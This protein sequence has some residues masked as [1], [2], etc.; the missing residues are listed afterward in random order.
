MATGVVTGIEELNA[1]LRQLRGPLA[2]KA[3]RKSSREALKPLAPK[4][5]RA[6]PQRTGRLS[7]A[8]KVRA[9]KR[10]RNKIGSRVTTSKSG[11]GFRGK[12]FYGWFIEKG[13]KT[14]R[15]LRNVDLGAARGVRRNAAQLAAA[16]AHDRKRRSVPG[17][18]YHRKTARNN[19][20]QVLARYRT[21]TRQ[22]IEELSQ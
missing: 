13:W 9:L 18:H 2:K 7:R 1:K 11:R 10:S 14:G 3:I 15:R 16:E 17:K 20:G 21:S 22:W 4:V 6:A 19:R 5:A 12:A 8:T